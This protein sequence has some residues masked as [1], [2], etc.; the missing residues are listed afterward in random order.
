MIFMGQR[1]AEQR[2][3]AVAHDLIDGSLIAMHRFH[4]V[5]EQGIKKFA[6]FLGITVREQL[7]RAL[8]ISEQHRD[9]LAL[10]FERVL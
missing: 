2:H 6:R 3:D 7:H 8:H 5:F 9:L 10:A 1:R 4:H